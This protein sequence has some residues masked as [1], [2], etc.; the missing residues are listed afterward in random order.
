M[1]FNRV[2]NAVKEVDTLLASLS[3][4]DPLVNPS[5]ERENIIKDLE[6]NKGKV[7]E[8]MKDLVSIEMEIQKVVGN[9]DTK[10][11]Q[12]MNELVNVVSGAEKTLEKVVETQKTK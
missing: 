8:A 7:K 3:L 12:S 10:V 1:D 5:S 2:R 9:D 6:E 11:N 4:T